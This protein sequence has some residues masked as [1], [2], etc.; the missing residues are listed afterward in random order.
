MTSNS[1]FINRPPTR[2]MPSWS[3][4]GF[5]FTSEFF[6]LRAQFSLILLISSRKASLWTARMMCFSVSRYR[7]TSFA[8][9]QK[10]HPLH[11]FVPLQHLATCFKRAIPETKLLQ[12][13]YLV[14]LSVPTEGS[15]MFNVSIIS[16][17][18]ISLSF[19]E[20]TRSYSCGICSSLSDISV[21]PWS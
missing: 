14:N 6:L 20:S 5:S 12:V 9:L 10:C 16:V 19:S 13:E 4:T 7:S 11:G 17:G 1:E 15:L 3:K 18:Q 21:L 8:L 2:K